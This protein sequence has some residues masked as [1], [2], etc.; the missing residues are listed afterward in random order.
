MNKK[1]IEY[2]IMITAIVILIYGC[3]SLHEYKLPEKKDNIT[4]SASINHPLSSG[5]KVVGD[6]IEFSNAQDFY[7]MKVS[8]V[9]FSDKK[10]TNL[11]NHFTNLGQ[12]TVDYRNETCYM[13]TIEFDD[14]SGYKYHSMIIPYDSF[15]KND[16]SFTKDTAVY[17]F[18]GNDRQ[19]VVDTVFNS[20]VVL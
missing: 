11:L 13:I 14:G 19:F 6:T 17:L 16:M 7:N 8:K 1:L 20:D 4:P 10:I 3:Y 18:E 2:L 12:G 15:D 9:N 5:Y